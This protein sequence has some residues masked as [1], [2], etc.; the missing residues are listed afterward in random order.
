MRRSDCTSSAKVVVFGP[1]AKLRFRK[2]GMGGQ[3]CSVW[4]IASKPIPPAKHAGRYQRIA[5][6]IRKM[7]VQNGGYANMM[8]VRTALSGCPKIG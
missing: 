2:K 8:I 6:S 3:A 7:R 1:E 5:R 4:H